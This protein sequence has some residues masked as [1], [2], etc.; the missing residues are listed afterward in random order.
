MTMVITIP[1]DLEARLRGE[2]ARRGEDAAEYARRLIE[3][4]L[5]P[6]AA[7]GGRDNRASLAVLDQWERQTATTDP[8]ELARRNAEFEAFKEA[9]NRNRLEAEGPDARKVFP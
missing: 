3:R 7:N 2:A 5:A 4:G 8:A 6:P 1:P 9:M